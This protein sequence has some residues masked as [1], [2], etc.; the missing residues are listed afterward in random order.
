MGRWDTDPDYDEPENDPWEDEVPPYWWADM[1]EDEAY[2]L[3]IEAAQLE[4]AA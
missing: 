3:A 4:A 2:W 1:D